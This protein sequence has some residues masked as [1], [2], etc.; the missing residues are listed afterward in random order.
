MLHILDKFSHC[1]RG[2]IPPILYKRF[3]KKEY[4]ADFINGHLRFGN[5]L[6]YKSLEDAGDTRC[7]AMEGACIVFPDSNTKFFIQRENGPHIPI[8]GVEQFGN[9]LEQPGLYFVLC[10]SHTLHDDQHTKFGDHLVT[11]TD[12][13]R[14]INILQGSSFDQTN[15]SWGKVSIYDDKNPNEETFKSAFQ[16]EGSSP[17]WMLKRVAYTTEYEFRITLRLADSASLLSNHKLNQNKL[18]DINSLLKSLTVYMETLPFNDT[19]ELS[20]S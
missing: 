17:L 6:Y 19:M 5:L 13:T 8:G 20:S 18:D 15:L 7:D 16:L 1:H 2:T 12:P 14:F 10:M 3:P 9:T 4:A 11:I